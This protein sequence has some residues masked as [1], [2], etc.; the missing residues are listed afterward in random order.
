MYFIVSEVDIGRTLQL[1]ASFVLI[2]GHLIYLV[3]TSSRD[4]MNGLDLESCPTG[5]VISYV[6]RLVNLVFVF[7]I[8]VVY[9]CCITRDDL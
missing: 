9:N 1:S 4:N 8:F 6:V 3:E 7:L 5:C 2:C